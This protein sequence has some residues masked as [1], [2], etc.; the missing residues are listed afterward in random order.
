MESPKK[1]M[2][3]S[4][5]WLR[6]AVLTFVFGFAVLGYLAARIYSDQPPI[7]RQVLSAAGSVLFT[8]DDIIEGQ[9]LFQKYGLMQFGTIFGHGAYLG[10]DFTAQYLHLSG[11]EMLN[12]Y[13]GQGLSQAEA[14]YRVKQELKTNAYDQKTGDLKFSSGQGHAFSRMLDFYRSWF[15]PREQQKGLRRPYLRDPEAVRK[16]TSYFAWSA[17]ASAALREDRAYTYTNNWP[18][19]PLADN[20]PT[21]EA[22]IWSVLSL[23]A[24]LGGTGLLL[25]AAGRY[26]WLGWEPPEQTGGDKRVFR[27]PGNVRLT[28][29][30]RATTWYFLVVAVLFLGQGA[31]GGVNAHYHVDPGSFYNIP[32]DKILPYNLSRTWHLQLALFFV[33]ASYLAMGIFLA[34]M[35]AG[36]E[37]RHQKKLAIALF[38]ALVVVVGGSLAGEAASILDLMD[39]RGSW[40]WIGNQGWEYLDLGRLWQFLLTAGLVFWVVILLRGLWKR[41]REEHPGNMPWLFLF[42]AVSIPLFYSAGMVFGKN[43][44]YAVTDFW[45]FWVVHLWVED[46]LELFTTIM[47][48]YLFV[49]LG[50]VRPKTAMIV[51]YLDIILYSVG[52]VIGTMHHLYFSGAP[53]LHMALGA[54][55][56]A[57]EV[58]PLLFLTYEA[59]R[60]MQLGTPPGGRTMLGTTSAEF[61][62]KWA[63]MFLIAVGFWNF[64]GAGIF[65]FLINLPVVSYYEIG[66]QFTANHGHGAL[67]GVYGMLAM[68]FFMFVA[69][70]FIPHDRASDRAMGISFWSLNIGLAWMV[71]LN[72][73]PIGYL[74]LV[75]SVNNSYWHA[76]S[77]EFYA[78]P[79]ARFFEW[80]RLPGDMIFILGGILPV[81]YLAVRMFLNRNRSIELPAGAAVEEFT[82]LTGRKS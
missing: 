1:E 16:L 34:P 6:G 20:A 64:L 59:W 62:H 52:G 57:M 74:Q 72:L 79:A 65:G 70:Y 58:I 5:F 8:R 41:L 32:L 61:P 2:L 4:R 76:R 42:S 19:E 24:L 44:E 33:S 50:M 23:I 60:F 77:P 56:S 66:T 45:R 78:Q 39:M 21:G 67:M 10:P 15:G 14:A 25:F 69:R 37:P 75:D 80:L 43:T 11:E 49:L 38:A 82:I 3:I 17:W 35:I 26:R 68:A 48:A 13:R 28:P 71:F 29:A 12:F 18:A 81:V 47:V 55:F 36:Q 27:E 73:F 54:F 22:L 30:Q 7:P 51:I 9:Q 63:V 40:F 31:L 46:F 53:A